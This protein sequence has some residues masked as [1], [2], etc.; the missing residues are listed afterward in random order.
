MPSLPYLDADALA[1]LL[2]WERA[3]DAVAASAGSVGGPPRTT[4]DVAAGQLMLMPAES[5]GAVGVKVLTIAPDNPAAGLPRIAAVYVLF[6]AVTLEPLALMDGAALTTIRTPAVSAAAVRALAAPDA[7][8]LVVFGAGPQGVAHVHAL[9]AVRPVERVR[10]VG[11][12]PGRAAAAVAELRAAGVD[13]EPGSPA[14]VADADL[15]VTATTSRAP[16]V[17][18]AQL[19]PYACVV[20]VGAHE[21]EA[22]ELDDTV[23]ARATRV[24]VEDRATALREAGEVVR[25]VTSGTLAETDLVTLADAVRTPVDEPTGITVFRSVGMAWEDLAVAEAAW[26]AHQQL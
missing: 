18:G 25:G 17:A 20:A 9:R 10:L 26:R 2:P 16:V 22:Y 21:P 7:R 5:A 13:A 6:N 12:D 24:V 4:L 15:V 3:V 23:L 1:A 8:R 19:A 11:R 14:D